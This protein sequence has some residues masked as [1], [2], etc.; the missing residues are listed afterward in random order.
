MF[1]ADFVITQPGTINNIHPHTKSSVPVL[2]YFSSTLTFARCL[3]LAA[4]QR[5]VEVH[6]VAL[7][8]RTHLADLLSQLCVFV[9]EG[10]WLMIEHCHMSS[11]SSDMLESIAKVYH[12]DNYLC[13][14]QKSWVSVSISMLIQAFLVSW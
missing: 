13:C 5:E 2:C 8:D 6:S 12:V 9:Q 11:E 4:S 14:I 7:I 10:C 1:G 3:K